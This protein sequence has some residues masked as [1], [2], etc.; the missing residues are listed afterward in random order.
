[1]RLLVTL[2][3]IAAAYCGLAWDQIPFLVDDS[4]AP[5][6][7]QA[8]APPPPTRAPRANAN[9][10]ASAQPKPP[11]ATNA[12]SPAKSADH[13]A[14]APWTAF[15]DARALAEARMLRGYGENR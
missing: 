7:T 15:A 2:I 4:T 11:V 5:S 8:A 9:A 12:E 1:M 13:D 14:I 6:K 10:T 3:L